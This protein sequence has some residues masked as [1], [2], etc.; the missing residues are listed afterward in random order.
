MKMKLTPGQKTLIDETLE[1]TGCTITV[2][3][4]SF[5]VT[6]KNSWFGNFP[7]LIQA[8]DVA[9]AI[10]DVYNDGFKAGLD[11]ASELASK[12]KGSVK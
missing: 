12:A 11:K 3:G 1:M 10:L 5:R 9:Y 4:S 2:E 7:S 6:S 8:R